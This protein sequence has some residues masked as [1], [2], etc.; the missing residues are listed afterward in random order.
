[1]NVRLDHVGLGGNYKTVSL[2]TS[3]LINLHLDAIQLYLPIGFHA[4][5]RAHLMYCLNCEN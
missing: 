3:I 1:M 5:F 4:T 2:A